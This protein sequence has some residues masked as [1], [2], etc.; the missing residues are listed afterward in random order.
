MRHSPQQHKVSPHKPGSEAGL[1]SALRTRGTRGN[2]PA[3]VETDSRWFNWSCDRHRTRSKCGVVACLMW[4]PRRPAIWS[5]LSMAV[6]NRSAERR[7]AS[8]EKNRISRSHSA[9]KSNHRQQRRHLEWPCAFDKG[10]R[11][12]RATFYAALL[13]GTLRHSTAAENLNAT[14]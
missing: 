13:S 10:L 4:P 11:R 3:A 2:P 6:T 9:R 5:K 14:W 7:C 12:C 1:K 8:E